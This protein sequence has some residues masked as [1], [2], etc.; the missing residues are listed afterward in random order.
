MSRQQNCRAAR[1][2]GGFLD[3][4]GLEGPREGETPTSG[5]GFPFSNLTGLECRKSYTSKII[6]NLFV[7]AILPYFPL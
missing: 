6:S 2:L 4:L 1:L 3:R 7:D 5:F